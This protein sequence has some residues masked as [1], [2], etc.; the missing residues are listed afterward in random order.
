MSIFRARAA[1]P[2]APLCMFCKLVSELHAMIETPTARVRPQFAFAALL[3]LAAAIR[4]LF[5]DVSYFNPSDETVYLRF[6]R[7]LADTSAY[8][9][10]VRM[11]VE[12]PSLW[13][14][15]NP[16]RWSYIGTLMLPDCRT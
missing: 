9:D 13:I 2:F 7:T 1:R 11:F 3:G 10:V 4:I 16:L 15:P 14:F 8:P 5:N 12:D 6:A